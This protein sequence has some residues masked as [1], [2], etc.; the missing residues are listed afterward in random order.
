MSFLTLDR[1][2]VLGFF[3]LGMKSFEIKEFL[4]KKKFWIPSTNN[5]NF[6]EQ[7]A[8]FAVVV[9][10]VLCRAQHIFPFPNCTKKYTGSNNNNNATKPI[11]FVY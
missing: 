11:H 5:L 7:S 10:A 6:F 4:H 2:S 3:F 8:N 1:V 9:A